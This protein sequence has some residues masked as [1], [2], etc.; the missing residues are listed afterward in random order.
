VA[1]DSRIELFPPAVWSI[2]ANVVAGGDG[3]A[4]QLDDWDVTIVVVGPGDGA[5]AARLSAA[6]WPLRYADEDGAMFVAPGR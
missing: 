2:Y 3:W 1:I 6:G 5:F 4:A